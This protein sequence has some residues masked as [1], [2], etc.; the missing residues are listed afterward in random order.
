[1]SEVHSDTAPS[2]SEPGAPLIARAELAAAGSPRKFA[3]PGGMTMPFRAGFVIVNT[4]TSFNLLIG[5]LSL[6]AATSGAIPIAAWGLLL[7][8]LIDGFDGPLARRWRVT[9][10]FGAQ[11][12]SLADMTSFIIAGAALTFYWVRPT[13]P[14]LLIAAVSGLYALSGAIRLARF[15]STAP[16]SAYFQGIPTTFGA[17]VVAANYLVNPAMDSYW[18]MALVSLLAVLMVSILPYP[19]LA[20]LRRCPPW[21]WLGL[22]IGL[23]LSPS[24]TVWVV[25]AAYICLGPT[26]WLHRHLRHDDTMTR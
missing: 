25:S 6:I 18:V 11:F 5:V 10:D 14:F 2:G 3:I 4:F 23:P 20:S 9:T 16:Q 7:C 19:K 13:A 12:D 1:M 21:L 17:V 22:A 8:V 24:W 26:I 15:N